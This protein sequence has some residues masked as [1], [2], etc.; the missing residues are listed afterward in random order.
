MMRAGRELDALVAEKVMGLAAPYSTDI[1]AAWLVVEHMH[2]R[3][4][5]AAQG[6]H[7][8]LTLMC[9]GHYRDCWA[10]SFDFELTDDWH[11]ADRIGAYPFA[12]RAETAPLAI[13]L[14]ALRTVGVEV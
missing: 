10:A 7:Q 1:A 2:A 12:A 5:P 13:C 14:A 4:D 11:E 8:L 3:L 6:A 9:V